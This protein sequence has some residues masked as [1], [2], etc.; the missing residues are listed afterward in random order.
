MSWRRSW[1]RSSPP[2]RTSV[3]DYRAGDDKARKKKRG[4][5]MGE[6]MKATRGQGNPQLLNRLLD[7][8]LS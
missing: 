1:T 6:A 8:R 3:A 4:F 5:L 7:T 2:T